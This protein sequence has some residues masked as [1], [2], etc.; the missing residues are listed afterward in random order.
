MQQVVVK[1]YVY[2]LTKE[3]LNEHI[4]GN[5]MT[6]LHRPLKMYFHECFQKSPRSWNACQ[7][8]N[9]TT[10]TSVVVDTFGY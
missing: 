3:F 5:S 7:K 10:L 6:I 8:V 9:M 4:Q 2:K 1:Y